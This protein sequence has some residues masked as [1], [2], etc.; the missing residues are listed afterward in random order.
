MRREIARPWLVE[1]VTT[2]GINADDQILSTHLLDRFTVANRFKGWFATIVVDAD[3]STAPENGLGTTT[4]RV[5][6]FDEATGALTVAGAAL[7]NEGAHQAFVDLYQYFHPDEIKRAYNRARS[8]VWPHL[9]VHRDHKGI[10][11]DFNSLTHPVPST[12]RAVDEVRLMR[13]LNSRHPD[14]LLTDGGFEDWTN[15]VTLANWTLAGTNSTVNQEQATTG[16]RNN[17][18]LSDQYSARVYVKN[19]NTTLKQTLTPSV[20]TQGVSVSMAAYVYCAVADVVSM[21]VDEHATS[22]FHQGTGWEW[23]Q[24][25]RYSGTNDSGF[26]VGFSFLGATTGHTAYL[27]RAVCFVGPELPLEGEPEKVERW[28]WSPQ[29]YRGTS[30]QTGTGGQITLPVRSNKRDVLQVIGRDLLSSVS[31]DTDTIEIDDEFVEPLAN[32]VRMLLCREMAKSNPRSDWSEQAD[33]YESFV[34]FDV[35]GAEAT[36]FAQPLRVPSQRGPF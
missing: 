17:L 34:P 19:N 18:V 31:A 27:D 3:G 8:L 4:R 35:T 14:N 15:E 16:P 21:L 28:A 26:D 9:S 33:M 11:T 32:T 30:A 24:Y 20:A 2:E 5:E 25:T 13:G 1:F 12:I 29:G 36:R 7:E 10:I 23:I 6:L 22:E